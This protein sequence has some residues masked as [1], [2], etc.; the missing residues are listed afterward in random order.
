MISRPPP[1][2]SFPASRLRPSRLLRS[3]PFLPAP[4]LS[5][6]FFQPSR[7]AF[8]VLL[9]ATYWIRSSSRQVAFGFPN[10][11][12][13][14]PAP[15]D[16]LSRR[17][18]FSPPNFPPSPVSPGPSSGPLP[19]LLPAASGPQPPTFSPPAVLLHL[20]LEPSTELPAP[21][22]P[23]P[24]ASDLSPS[25]HFSRPS[26]PSTLSPPGLPSRN[27]P[28]SPLS[29]LAAPPSFRLPSSPA[30][31]GRAFRTLPGQ[32]TIFSRSLPGLSHASL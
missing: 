21:P 31:P 16:L 14:S 6:T 20:S 3:R 30:T 22:S 26:P 24:A 19:D 9:S 4:R 2:S 17:P 1:L 18:S 25:L 10:L 23:S 5:T 13:P 15:S 11:L 8:E 29:F 27:P 12:G 32:P 28:A 7:Q